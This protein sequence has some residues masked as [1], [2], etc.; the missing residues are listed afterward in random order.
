MTSKL[1]TVS[2]ITICN[3]ALAM[4]GA[5]MISS[6][7]DPTAEAKWCR[8]LYHTTRRMLLRDHP[9]SSCTKRV[10]LAP[11][12]ASPAFGW[13]NQYLLPPD[14]VR[15]LSA[16]GDGHAVES[17]RLLSNANPVQLV[18]VW[19]NESEST[20][21]DLLIEAM[22]LKLAAKLARPVTGSTTDAQVR[23]DEYQ[24]LLKRARAI[25]AQERPSEQLQ[26]DA[27]S[28]LEGRA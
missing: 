15:L 21:D 23:E 7:D 20:W 10:T 25:N 18:Y 2:C 16:G 5:Q 8:Q 13:S 6:F 24:R 12:S 22:G 11:L 28:L 14:F 4:I 1:N 3:S 9:W 17:G 26:Y 19:D 27:S